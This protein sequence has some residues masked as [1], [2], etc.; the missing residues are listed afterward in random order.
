MI[1]TEEARIEKIIIHKVGNKQL[2]EGLFLANNTID[3]D[4]RLK[5]SLFDY[6]LSSFKS[7]EY[8]NFSHESDIQLNET[9]SCISKIFENT[10]NFIEESKNLSQHLYNCSLHPK[11]KEGEFYV[12]YFNQLIVDGEEVDAIGLFKSEIKET[13]LKI[14]QGENGFALQA[15]DG[16]NLNK[17]QKGCIV[18]NTEQENGFVLSIVDNLKKGNEAGYWKDA[19]LKVKPR[20]DDYFQTKNVM[21]MYKDF[22]TEQLPAEFEISKA[23]QADMMN[24]SMKFLNEKESFDINDFENEVIEQPEVKDSF[25]NYRQKYEEEK[26]VKINDDFE[27]SLP[28]VKKHQKAFKSVIK[29]DKN[30]HVYVHGNRQR[31]VKGYDENTGLHYYQLFFEEE[32]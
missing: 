7:N 10:G 13:F 14:K 3:I 21:T 26:Q 11:V 5:P 19:F 17:L 25:K 16:I 6:F 12:V 22:V 8:Y 31:I 30:F 4:E 29:L 20:Q 1:I 24:K 18:F 28:A 32:K 23:D 2:E 9:F 27:V 15:E